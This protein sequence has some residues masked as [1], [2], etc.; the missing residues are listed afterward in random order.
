MAIKSKEH[1]ENAGYES[2][3]DLGQQARNPLLGN[4]EGEN[5][6]THN[7]QRSGGNVDS[8]VI[9]HIRSC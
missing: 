4:W 9:N 5:S 7:T 6:S 8:T 1:T 2:N 3:T